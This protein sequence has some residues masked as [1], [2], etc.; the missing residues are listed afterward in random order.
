MGEQEGPTVILPLSSAPCSSSLTGPYS[1]CRLEFQAH[2]SVRKSRLLKSQWMWSQSHGSA[3]CNPCSSSQHWHSSAPPEVRHSGSAGNQRGG[4]TLR[5]HPSSRALYSGPMVGV[6]ALIHSE[7]PSV[8]FFHCFGEQV[9]ASIET[10]DLY[11]FPHQA[12]IK[13][14]SLSVLIFCNV[15]RLGIFQ[16]IKSC[17]LFA[18]EFHF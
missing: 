4:P 2:G 6:A 7:S 9:L 18:R 3:G 1:L 16:T 17:F 10:A 12:K 15:G 11:Q 8:S 13:L 5:N 14:H